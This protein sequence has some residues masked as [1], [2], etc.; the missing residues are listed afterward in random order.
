MRVTLDALDPSSPVVAA[1]EQQPL[2]RRLQQSSAASKIV[3]ID[4][5]NPKEV[6]FPFTAA[7]LGIGNLTFTAEGLDPAKP[8]SDRVL[9]R[10]PEHF[11][12]LFLWAMI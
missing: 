8:A 11:M 9:V 1:P 3:Q 7:S 10:F 2:R 6:R 12:K 4:A 5:A